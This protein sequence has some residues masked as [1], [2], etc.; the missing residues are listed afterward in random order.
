M[1]DPKKNLEQRKKEAY[2]LREKH[3]K[4]RKQREADR[5]KI[6]TD[7]L[8]QNLQAEKENKLVYE[9]SKKQAASDYVRDNMKEV[10][11]HP[12]WNLP[13][14]IYSSIPST[15]INLGKGFR[16]TYLD[17]KRILMTQ[18]DN[19]IQEG[20]SSVTNGEYSLGGNIKQQTNNMNKITT[21]NEGGLH[22]TNPNGGIPMGT[23][24]EGQMNTVE[25]GEARMG[26]M[27]YS[28]RIPLSQE[29]V[30]AVGLPRKFT[31]K[32]PGQIMTLIDKTFKGRNDKP[33]QDTKKDIADKVAQAQEMIKTQQEAMQTQSQEVPDIM[34]GEVPQGMEQYMTGGE[35]DLIQGGTSEMINSGMNLTKNFGSTGIDVSGNTKYDPGSLNLTQ[36]IMSGA[37][38]GTKLGAAGRVPLVGLALGV[39]AGLYGYN[40][41]K[42]DMQKAV[43]NSQKLDF[44]T[45]TSDFAKGGKM[46]VD[47]GE[48]PLGFRKPLNTIPQVGAPSD[49]IVMTPEKANPYVFLSSKNRPFQET[50]ITAN[51]KGIDTTLKG[52]TLPE[53]YI[54]SSK[55]TQT[56]TNPIDWKNVGDK[57]GK[58]IKENYP[59]ALRL[60]PVA[61]NVAELA[62]LK[63]KGYD[64]VNP[65]LNDTRF[66]PEYIDEKSALNLANSEMNNTINSISQM[67]G[68]EGA[69]RN[70]VLAASL[71]RGKQLSQ[72]MIDAQGRNIA[73][74][75]FGQQFNNQNTE[76]NI[77]RR[78]I[79]EDLTARNKG[80]YETNRSKLVGQL[81]TD[82]GSIGKEE[83]FK[84]I[85]ENMTGYDWLGNYLKINPNAS[86]EEVVAAAQEEMKKKSTSYFK[87]RPSINTTPITAAYGGKM[88]FKKY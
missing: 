35:L 56:N 23:S 31:G 42:K 81:G 41:Q 40:K 26:D 69:N 78:A 20:I 48:G 46:Y 11:D 59:H 82:I 38:D 61:M 66:K 75:Q 16:K 85:A 68:S 57:V 86:K 55:S 52:K 12:L 67:G 32:T 37:Q 15:A 79:A 7:L 8:N 80:A 45:N 39:G 76:A 18:A 25:Q 24:P 33:S 51:Y 70:A 72:S 54:A 43:I 13:G 1:T 28:D 88:K 83:V 6:E 71:N 9:Q 65:I 3:L 5:K 84:D 64:K 53:N 17:G 87:N 60:A 10:V 30:E 34:N 36:S 58:G 74:N 77:Q 49:G 73:T 4:E 62:R 2:A 47:G 19:V 63:R 27:I 44:R 50:P 21:Y 29:A 14:N 22:E